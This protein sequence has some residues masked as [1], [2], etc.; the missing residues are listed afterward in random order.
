MCTFSGVFRSLFAFVV[1]LA[2]P[3]AFEAFLASF[4]GPFLALGRGSVVFLVGFAVLGPS[5]GGLPRFR[6]LSRALGAFFRFQ[7]SP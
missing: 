5:S 4:F 2:R 1:W 3:F 6:S 7:P